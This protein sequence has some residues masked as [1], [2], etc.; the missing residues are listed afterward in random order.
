[1]SSATE[2]I[3][4]IKGHGT[5]ND[6]I[7]VPDLAGELDLPADWVRAVCSRHTGLGA[8]GVIRVVR[9]GPQSPVEWGR[10]ADFV[11]DH[12]NADGSLAEMCGNGARVMMRYLAEAGLIGGSDP[13]LLATRGGL[14]TAWVHGTD[15]T[16]D[17]TVNMGSATLGPKTYVQLDG[18]TWPAQGALLPNPHAVVVVEDLAD[19]GDLAGM[20]TVPAADFPDGVNVEFVVRQAPDRLSMRV[21]ERGV[22]E[23]LACGTGACAVAY[24]A[25]SLQDGP[26][27]VQQPGGT[28][29]ISLAEDGALLLS[30]PAV[31]VASGVFGP[32]SSPVPMTPMTPMTP[33]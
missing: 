19:A 27:S 13:V 10:G 9:G 7:V 11:M 3:A 29:R 21:H 14:R 20:P 15:P 17:I 33:R 1:M 12:R 25:G 22:G 18:R 24:V 30:G 23:T 26:V 32:V 16:G 2:A 8:D 31:L 6:F 28:V 5:G 4:F